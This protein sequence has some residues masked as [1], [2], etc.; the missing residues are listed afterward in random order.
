M[1]WLLLFIAA[2]IAGP[3]MYL[4]YLYV[5]PL[6]GAT[7]SASRICVTNQSG[8]A[9]IVSAGADAGAENSARLEDGERLCAPSTTEND[10]GTVRVFE[11]EDAVEGCSRLAK[12]GQEERLLRYSSFDNCEWADG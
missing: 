10:T 4:L 8:Q 5:F 2:L 7:F 9:L 1:R 6:Q 11:S 3:A 12:A